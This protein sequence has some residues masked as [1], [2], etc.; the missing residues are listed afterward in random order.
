MMKRYAVVLLGLS[1]MI[2]GCVVQPTPTATPVPTPIATSTPTATVAP[3]PE[4]TPWVAPKPTYTYEVGVCTLWNLGEDL[5][6]CSSGGVRHELPAGQNTV[7]AES[8][9]NASMPTYCRIFDGD[10]LVD[11][12]VQQEGQRFVTCSAP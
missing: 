1:L 5:N 12:Q 11:W 3:T 4:N 6:K 2:G 9:Y 8:E 7:Q 10:R